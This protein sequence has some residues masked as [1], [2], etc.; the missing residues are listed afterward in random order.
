MLK[1]GIN[2]SDIVSGQVIRKSEFES[3][4]EQA[5]DAFYKELQVD[6]IV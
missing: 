3:V 4:E 2:W 5:M 6:G 1:K